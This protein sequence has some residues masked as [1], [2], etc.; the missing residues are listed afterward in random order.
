MKTI[1]A[2]ALLAMLAAAEAGAQ[3]VNVGVALREW[4]ADLDGRIQGDGSSGNGT[5]VDL[6][7]DLGVE[8][9][10]Q[11]HELR[12]WADVPGVGRFSAGYGLVGFEGEETIAGDLRFDDRVFPAGTPVRTD[13]DL[14]FYSVDY[15]YL[16][17]FP[18]FGGAG[19]VELGPLV[20]ARLVTGDAELSGGGVSA[21][22]VMHRPLV[23]VG[24]HA[25]VEILPGWRA[26]AVVEGIAFTVPK[27]KA[28]YLEASFETSVVLWRGLF[29]GAGYRLLRINLESPDSSTNFDLDALLTGPTLTV[30]WRF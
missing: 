26:D 12:A 9:P 20:G 14:D 1:G 3:E 2:C 4:M 15:E 22:A 23:I 17:E 25:G 28:R 8:G 18:G 21:S 24:G 7:E 19:K 10:E 27:V 16:Y 30:G 29:A 13:L 5:R 6:E 11:G